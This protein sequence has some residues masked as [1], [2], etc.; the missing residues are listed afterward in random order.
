M[1]KFKNNFLLTLTASI[2]GILLWLAWPERGLTPLIFVAFVPLLFVEHVYS[3]SK[4]KVSSWKIFF[5]YYFSFLLWNTLTTYWIYYSSDVGC[6]VAIGLNSF[7]MAVVWYL[8]HRVKKSHGPGPGYFSLIF[9]W[10]AFEYLHLNWE[11]TWP[12]LTLGNVFSTHPEWIQWYEFTGALGGSLWILLINLFVFQLAKNF[13]YRDLLLRLRKINIIFLTCLIFTLLAGPTI[14]SLYFYY[15][16]TEKGIPTEVAIVQPNVDPYNEKFSGSGADQL[17]RILRLTSSVV[18]TG[19]QYVLA[20]ETAIPEGLWE[21]RLETTRPVETIRTY[22]DGFPNLNMIIGFTSFKAYPDSNQRTITARKLNGTNYYYDVFNAAMMIGN[23]QPI[24]IYHKSKLVPGVEKMPYPK[25]F[26]FLEKYA[27]ELGGTSGSLGTQDYRNSFV[28]MDGTKIAPAICYE[29]I[30]GDFMSG[31][32]RD[33]SQFI[34]VITNDGWW[35]NTPGY[36][37]HMNYARLMAVEFRKDVARSANTGISCFINQRGDVLAKTEWWKEDALKATLYRNEIITFYG[38]NGDYI[39]FIC[40]FMTCSVLLYFGF[41]R[42]I[43][44]F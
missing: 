11:I 25:I 2:T 39:G 15:K 40:A 34:A 43:S 9:F 23:A 22:L 37:Q 33:S 26:G 10:I 17:A 31:Y 28:A 27:L 20:P 41:K 44:L 3:R 18:D 12:W 38:R 13:W 7:F 19:T 29:S 24:Q 42:L 14:V 4:S 32:I 35:R 36:R 16:H 6:Y 30:Y 21:D 1:L 5:N 8:F